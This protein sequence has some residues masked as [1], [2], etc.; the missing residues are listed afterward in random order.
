MTAVDAIGKAFSDAL[1]EVMFS[2]AIETWLQ[3]RDRSRSQSELMERIAATQRKRERLQADREAREQR[4]APQRARG[5]ALYQETRRRMAAELGLGESS[6]IAAAADRRIPG[7]ARMA[8]PR[9]W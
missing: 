7:P 9:I 1:T 3:E 5:E 2:R 4:L 8:A 6:R